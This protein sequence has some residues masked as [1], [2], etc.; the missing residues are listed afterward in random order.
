MQNIVDAHWVKTHLN[1][2]NLV[3]LDAS[4]PT[5]SGKLSELQ[6][7]TIPGAIKFDLKKEFSD[8]NAPFPNTIPQPE[9]FQENA[10]ELGIN[11]NDIIVVFDNLGIYSAPRVWWLFK[12]M[13]H[14]N[15]AV[16]NGGLPAW[17]DLGLDT[18][19]NYKTPTQKGNF[20]ASFNPSNVILFEQVKSN[21]EKADFL[22]ID[23]RSKGRFEG[24]APEPRKHLKSGKIPHSVNLPFQDVL[25][26]GYFKSPNELKDLFAHLNLSDRTIVYSCG[27]GLTACIIL[28]AGRIAGV[29]SMK[30][31]DGSWTEW[32]ELNELLNV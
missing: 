5:A 10:Q 8:Q 27:S 16:M 13:G 22:I 23:A 4:M 19:G 2:T 30:I 28:L 11:T 20:A 24:T 21:V 3:L 9:I 25:K 26:N 14:E 17:I 32:A 18:A 1:D 31:Y 29:E 6:G 12:T 7:H 15:V